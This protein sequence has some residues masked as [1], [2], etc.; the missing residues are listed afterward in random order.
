MAVFTVTLVLLSACSKGHKGDEAD[1]VNQP[2]KVMAQAFTT[3]T[4]VVIEDRLAAEDPEGQALSF[5][6]VQTPLSGQLF[7][8]D[9]G[10]FTYL[11]NE[12]VTGSDSFVFSVSDGVN[13]AVTARGNI[14]IE[15]LMVNFS[16][17]S[18]NALN[19]QADDVPL[20]L[21]GRTFTD[22]VDSADFYQDLFLF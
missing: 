1:P 15:A 22:D 10:V 7:L 9:D 5:T 12:E 4:E 19:Q 17:F 20:S 16:S 6:L 18:R 21:N 11:P 13:P 2:P 8:A 3:Q 14:T